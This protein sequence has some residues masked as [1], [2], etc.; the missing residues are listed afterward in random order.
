MLTTATSLTAPTAAHKITL[1][2]I[3]DII[4]NSKNSFFD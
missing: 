3:N 2:A 1:N 4:S